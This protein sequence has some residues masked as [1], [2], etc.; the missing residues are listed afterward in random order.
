MRIRTCALLASAALFAACSSAGGSLT[1]PNAPQALTHAASADSTTA[2]ALDVG[3]AGNEPLIT[4]APDGTL[5]IAALANV[6]R[7]TDSGASW[8]LVPNPTLGSAVL[9]SDSA[10]SADPGGRLYYTFDYPYAGNTA[11]CTSDDRGNTWS[12]NPAVVPGG[13]DRMWIVSPSTTEAFETTNEGL[14]QTTFM[15]SNDRGQTWTPQQFGN[16]VTQPQ[17]GELSEYNPGTFVLQPLNENGYIFV[18]RFNPAQQINVL[19]DVQPTGVPS[20]AALP[21]S[22]M[23]HDGTYFVTGEGTNAAGG[24]QVVIGRTTNQGASFS[25]LPPIPQ[26][27][28]GT[29]AFSAIAA[30]SSGHV[31]VLY[32]YTSANGDPGS[33]TN[34]TW[35]IVYAETYNALGASPTWKTTTLDTNVHTGAI[36]ASL[37]CSGSDRFAGDFISGYMD[38]ADAANLT[39]VKQDA[40]ATSTHIRFARIARR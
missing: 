19:S 23:G 14:Y 29:A 32:Y 33:L 35:S 20:G 6:Y 9:A 26:T 28:K 11:V 36:C 8:T 13:T 18:Y 39:W 3:T 16:A 10:I 38:A 4:G 22:S 17:T 21:G 31:G 27:T 40:G 5:Y 34:A 1:P 30:G 2:G 15:I 24:R 7:S 12:C 25:I 37:S